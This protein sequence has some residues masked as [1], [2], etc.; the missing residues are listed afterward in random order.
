MKPDE[1]L[2]L[3]FKITADSRISVWHISLY[4]ALLMLWQQGGFQKQVKISRKVLMQNAHIASITTYHKC[5]GQLS[6]LGYILY[7][8]T[9]DRFMGSTIQILY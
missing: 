3:Y 4:M 9:Y 5:I 2:Q 8:P 6:D 1:I 7:E